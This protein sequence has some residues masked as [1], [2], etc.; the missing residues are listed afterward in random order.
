MRKFSVLSPLQINPWDSSSEP[1]DENEEPEMED[2]EMGDQNEVTEI[3]SDVPNSDSDSDY[4]REDYQ[5]EYDRGLDPD[6]AAEIKKYVSDYI[7]SNNKV[8]STGEDISSPASST[9]SDILKRHTTEESIKKYFDDKRDDNY[10]KATQ[11]HNHNET[12][13]DF[14]NGVDFEKFDE[15]Q[16]NIQDAMVKKTEAIAQKRYEVES[17]F[18]ENKYNKDSKDNEN[19]SNNS[20]LDYVIEQQQCEM[21]PINESDGGE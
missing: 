11:A 5:E 12:L 19:K 3:G 20:P 14:W 6:Y 18:F 4:Y 21:P 8:D 2:E 15:N 17:K 13:V 9:V 1:E 7:N 16:K 10:A